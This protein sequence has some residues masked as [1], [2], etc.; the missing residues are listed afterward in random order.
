MTGVLLT[1]TFLA[2][3]REAVERAAREASLPIEII[4]H[5]N[6]R[7]STLGPELRDSVDVAFLSGDLYPGNFRGFFESINGCANL[8]WVQVFY[9]GVEGPLWVPLFER[10]VTLTKAAGASAQAIAQTAIGGV[11][12]LSR[13]FQHWQAAQRDHAWRP[14]TAEDPLAPRD[15]RD[16]TMVIV[17]VGAIG[18]HIARLAKALGMTVVGVRRMPGPEI[19]VDE[20]VH[21]SGLDAVLPRADWLTLACPLTDETRGLIDARRLGLL[22]QGAR[23]ANVARGAVIDEEAMIAALRSGRLGGAY[24]DVFAAEPLPAESPLW[25]LPNVIVTPHN[26]TVSASKYQREAEVFLD[27][28]AR[29]AGGAPLTNLVTAL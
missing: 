6:E 9:V 18:G 27:N 20:V 11:L 16:Q 8:K 12:M 10:G 4:V 22:P 14:L 28:L 21:P 15:L 2:G 19:N 13:P 17:G 24:L 23:I 25:D 5:E 29:W 3:Y 1:R 7:G 26:S